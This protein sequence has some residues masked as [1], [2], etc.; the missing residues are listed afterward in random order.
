V[1]AIGKKNW[2]HT[3]KE[4]SA[5]RL[6]NTAQT[7]GSQ[8]GVCVLPGLRGKSKDFYLHQDLNRKCLKIVYRNSQRGTRIESLAG[9]RRKSCVSQ[10][11]GNVPETGFGICN[12]S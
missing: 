10:P 1:K 9:N 2:L 4:L 12:A 8:L 5:H 6:R 3:W 11:P 7:I